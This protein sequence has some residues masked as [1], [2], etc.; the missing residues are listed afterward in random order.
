MIYNKTWEQINSYFGPVPTTQTGADIITMITHWLSYCT[1]DSYLTCSLTHRLIIPR[2]RQSVSAPVLPS[3]R[4][5]FYRV[6]IFGPSSHPPV[7][8]RGR[9]GGGAFAFLHPVFLN[10]C[11]ANVSPAWPVGRGAEVG[12]IDF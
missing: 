1:A 7:D 10:R 2:L 4:P 3:Q 11:N 5:T 9:R 8:S 12:Q 6:S